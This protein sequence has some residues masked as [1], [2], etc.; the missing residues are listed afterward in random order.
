[1][2]IHSRLC[3]EKRPP[4]AKDP[5]QIFEE[6][7]QPGEFERIEK[8]PERDDN[9]NDGDEHVSPLEKSHAYLRQQRSY[10]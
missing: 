8:I 6:V 2:G 7:P 1:L 5:G 3:K 4:E 10:Y 9:G